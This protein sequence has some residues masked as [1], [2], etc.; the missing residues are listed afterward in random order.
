MPSACEQKGNQYHCE[1]HSIPFS[2]CCFEGSQNACKGNR[3][4][5]ERCYHYPFC[6]G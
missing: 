2:S 5:A 6:F 4:V 3:R 1:Q